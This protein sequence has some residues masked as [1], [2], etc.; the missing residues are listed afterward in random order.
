M[1]TENIN[2]SDA[3]RLLGEGKSVEET[4][5]MAERNSSADDGHD[6][7]IGRPARIIPRFEN[8]SIYGDRG[9]TDAPPRYWVVNGTHVTSYAAQADAEAAAIMA[10]RSYPGQTVRVTKTLKAFRTRLPDVETLESE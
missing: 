8:R 2:A 5:R 10:A 7:Q 4:L 6:L 3:I 9:V 1:D